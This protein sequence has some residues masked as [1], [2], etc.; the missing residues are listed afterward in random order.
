MISYLNFTNPE[1]IETKKTFYLFLICILCWLIPLVICIVIFIYGDVGSL[2]ETF[3]WVN[4]DNVAFVYLG[5]CFLNYVGFFIALYKIREGIKII[6][7]QTKSMDMYDTYI[8]VFLKFTLVVS[9]TFCIF[10]LNVSTRITG[11]IGIY[12]PGQIYFAIALVAQLGELIS[13]P[14][15]VIT[16]GF[17]ATRFKELKSILCF[18]KKDEQYT[19]DIQLEVENAIK[20]VDENKYG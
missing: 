9:L 10:S 7:K 12:L 2:G 8:S 19:Q 6:L 4:N 16:Y 18:K 14:L 5:F 20:E 15:Y 1:I 11:Y 3:C 13:C 17:N